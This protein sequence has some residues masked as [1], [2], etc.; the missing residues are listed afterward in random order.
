M[1]YNNKAIQTKLHSG[2]K[3]N[4]MRAEWTGVFG[5]IHMRL[6][7]REDG[8]LQITRDLGGQFRETAY[9]PV[10]ACPDGSW[11]RRTEDAGDLFALPGLCVRVSR[12]SG[13]LSFFGEDGTLLLRERPECPAELAPV[14]I[15]RSVFSGETRI[16]E[17]SGADGAR[18]SAAPAALKA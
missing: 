7:A 16:T 10:T 15:R 4:M 11:T 14:E 2:R 13:A 6:R 18:A 3:E 1:E 17:T 12:E 9:S 5:S 8:I